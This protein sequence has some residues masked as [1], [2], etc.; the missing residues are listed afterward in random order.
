MK[1]LHIIGYNNL[2]V[3]IFFLLVFFYLVNVNERVLISQRTKEKL[4]RELQESF[5]KAL[6]E[7]EALLNLKGWFLGN[8]IQYTISYIYIC[9]SFYSQL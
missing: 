4:K 8:H 3:I 6:G 5:Q 9:F 1:G 7:A 2:C